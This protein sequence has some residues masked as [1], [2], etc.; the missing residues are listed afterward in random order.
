MIKCPCCKKKSECRDWMVE[1]SAM[2]EAPTLICPE[3]GDGLT[4]SF[5]GKEEVA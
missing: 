2:L 3:C 5:A 4:F 1:W